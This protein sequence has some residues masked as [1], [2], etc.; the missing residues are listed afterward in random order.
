[1]YYTFYNER[2]HTVSRLD[3]TTF[4]HL[5]NFR[6]APYRLQLHRQA[7]VVEAPDDPVA[8]TGHHDGVPGRR[9]LGAALVH[10]AT[11]QVLEGRQQLL[12]GPRRGGAPHAVREE[13]R[14]KRAA[15]PVAAQGGPLLRRLEIAAPF[16][17][18]LVQQPRPCR[19]G[20]DAL[21][22][23]VL[24]GADRSCSF[25]A[26]APQLV[27]IPNV[28][29]GI[30]AGRHEVPAVRCQRRWYQDLGASPPCSG[31]KRGSRVQ[32]VLPE[33]GRAVKP[34]KE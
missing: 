24:A 9:H 29:V 21:R 32:A 5:R 2:S 27:E 11:V 31:K 7:V 26:F 20:R 22:E 14:P 3:P 10:P 25:G 1:M 6:S 28:D 18:F 30:R 23:E 19:H 17:G 12:L 15:I 34:F 33:Y 4:R 16:T 8:A 13:P